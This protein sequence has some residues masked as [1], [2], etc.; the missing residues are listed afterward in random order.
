MSVCVG[1]GEGS[2]GHGLVQLDGFVGT[3]EFILLLVA[4]VSLLYLQL[5]F[6]KAGPRSA[7]GKA[8]DS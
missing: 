5:P 4:S 2:W 7:V 3:P 1:G 6:L 8:P